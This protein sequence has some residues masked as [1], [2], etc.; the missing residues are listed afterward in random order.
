MSSVTP[1]LTYVAEAEKAAALYVSL[2]KNSR[3]QSM[4]QAP[5]GSYSLV[6]FE[7]DGRPF[8]AM[9]AGPTFS[10]TSGFSIFV[11]CQDQVEVDRLWEGLT[12]NGGQAGNCG[13]LT[14]PWGVSWQIIPRRFMELSGDPDP[15]RA[16]RAISA[17]LNMQKLIIRDLE[18]AAAGSE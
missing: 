1:F 16:Q 9:N 13:W 14:D 4:V 3:I 11:E 17:M 10:F 2:V 15:A 12:A 8:T 5:D 18:K 7:L 6:Q